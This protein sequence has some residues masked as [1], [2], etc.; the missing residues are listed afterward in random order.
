[1]RRDG[2]TIESRTRHARQHRA[3]ADPDPACRAQHRRDRSLPDRGRADHGQQPRG[4][5]DRRRARQAARAAG[6]RRAACRRAHLAQP[7]QVRRQRRPRAFHHPAAAGEAGRHADQR[8][9]AD[10][11][12]DARTVPAEDQRVPSHHLR[13]LRAPGRAAD[14]LFRQ[15]RA[16]CARR[17]RGAGRRRPRLCELGEHLAHAARGHPAGGAERTHH[18]AAVPR[19]PERSRQAPSGDAR[20]R[21]RRQADPPQW[22]RWFRLVD[23]RERQGHVAAARPG[24]QAGA[25]ALARGRGPRGAAP[26]RSHLAVGARL[27]R[28]RAASRPAAPAVALADEAAR[29]R[30]RGV[31]ARRARPP[32]PDRA[33]DHGRERRRRDADDAVRERRAR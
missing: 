5:L 8:A 32:A 28:R 22:S 13:P 24:Q 31:A 19:A 9:L 16:L 18:R 15:H 26:V 21:R 12:P 7:A 20:P 29:S 17:R 6:L 10:R 25:G 4:G 30:R 23:T 11:L 33:P 3:R 14:H 2:E 27:R 1:M